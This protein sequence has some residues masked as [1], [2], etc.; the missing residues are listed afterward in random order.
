MHMRKSMRLL[1]LLIGASSAFAS[2]LMDPLEQNALSQQN[3]LLIDEPLLYLQADA[4]L[5]QSL[6]S[7]NPEAAMLLHV[8]VVRSDLPGAAAP[9]TGDGGARVAATV[10][11][12]SA[13]LQ[14]AS[15]DEV[16]DLSAALPAEQHSR[17]LWQVVKAP[18]R[19]TLLIEHRIVNQQHDVIASRYPDIE[20][21]LQPAGQDR[22]RALS[23]K[24]R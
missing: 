2:E 24:E 17:W 7:I 6:A 12:V 22:Y 8:L 19:T 16:A 14:D 5:I 10:E 13:A 11:S 21:E 15:D 4:A 9:A 3:I 20:I 18:E 23:W 1:F